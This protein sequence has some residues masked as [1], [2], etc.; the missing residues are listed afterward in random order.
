M[1]LFVIFNIQKTQKKNTPNK[2]Q[3]KQ[4][5]KNKQIKNPLKQIITSPRVSPCDLMG[6]E[7]ILHENNYL[8]TTEIRLSAKT[9]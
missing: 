9:H 3:T 7:L 8:K 5:P 2:T 6:T 4:K 1:T